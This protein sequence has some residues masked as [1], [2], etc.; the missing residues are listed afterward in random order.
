MSFT[1]T[2]K[3]QVPVL[4]AASVARKVTVVLPVIKEPAAGVCKVWVA[5]EQLSETVPV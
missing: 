5:P 4:A 2:R 1:V 3:V